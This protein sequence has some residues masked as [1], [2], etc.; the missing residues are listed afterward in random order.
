MVL[1]S[2][3]GLS[4]FFKN[5]LGV[6]KELSGLSAIASIIL[7]LQI[8]GYFKLLEVGTYS[9][10]VIGLLFSGY[11]GINKV[12]QKSFHLK[13]INWI[14]IWLGLYFGLI[15]SALMINKL[16]HYDNF[17]HWSL[18]VKFLFTEN[19]FPTA[20]DTIISFTSYPLG[21]SLFLYYVTKI[22]GFSD[23]V[24]LIGQQ[25]FIF[26]AIYATF[27][28]LRD[29]QRLLF[30]AILFS[31]FAVINY[32]NI[33]IRMNNL[34][35][36][37]LL[38][39][40]AL[41][42]IAGVVTMR[43][44]PKLSLIYVILIL[45]VLNLVKNS[46][47]FFSVIVLFIYAGTIFLSTEHSIHSIFKKI[48]MITSG[49]IGAILPILVWMLHVKQT[50]PVSKHE[51]SVSAYQQLL[52]DKTASEVAA[53]WSNFYSTVLNLSTQS[54]QGILLTNLLLIGTGLVIH[55]RLKRK[56]NI[57][58]YWLGI[59]LVII[60]YYASILAMFL[61]SMPTDEALYLA[62]FE[63]YTS[64]IVIFA[65]GLAVFVLINEIDK[66]MYEQRIVKRNHQGF[67]NLKTKKNYQYTTAILIF[68]S[69]LFIF[70]ESNGL[71]FNAT[72]FD[73]SIP[74]RFKK[75][76]L[77]TIEKS[78]D[79]FLVVTTDKTAVEN[80]LVNF[81]GKYFLFSEN[82]EGREDFVLEE[83]EFIELLKQYDYIVVLEEH[84]TFNKLFEK[85]F[86]QSLRNGI[87]SIREL[88]M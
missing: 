12:R 75:M 23:Q 87:H 54:T 71:L 38:P 83:Q 76:K 64:S 11:E 73:Q 57:I 44:R 6:A 82:V 8:L 56:T 30:P 43:D 59:N 34:L 9:L 68:V 41:A 50:F 86:D 81:V 40:L 79:S 52:A 10:F 70:S 20:S 55:Y 48:G 22:A 18:I 69:T 13:R 62:G 15:A 65:L 24:L 80:Y 21:S 88:G 78:S 72:Q 29:K 36:D 32:Y 42:A 25:I 5:G 77:D 85:N 16:E 26:S 4:L 39:L 45:A 3:Y 66:N 60:C 63:R 84:Y 2:I 7:I 49:L 35:V 67:K 31:Y 27:S 47:L 19:R 17:S 37:F 46:G 74:S 61:F 53:I 28:I 33:A 1:L 58:W 51:V 14:I